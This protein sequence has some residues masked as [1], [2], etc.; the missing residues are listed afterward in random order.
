MTRRRLRPRAAALLAAGAYALHQLRYV[1]GYGHRA[2]EELGAQGHAY[3]T[4]LAPLLAVAIVL[5]VADLALRLVIARRGA[6]APPRLRWSWPVAA[7][8]LLGAYA[9]QELAE[10]ALAAGHPAGAAALTG[11]GGWVALPLA[12]AI[13][14]VLALLARGA[15]EALEL[16]AEPAPRVPRPRPGLRVRP[17]GRPRSLPLRLLEVPAPARGPPLA[18]AA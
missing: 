4:V 8:C 14:L 7:L 10:G 6:A 9:A 11:H 5:L 13:G 1:A 16:A 17:S 18:P 3:M 2:H 12:G 15:H